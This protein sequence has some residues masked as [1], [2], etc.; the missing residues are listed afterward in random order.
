MTRKALM[1]EDAL[2][3]HVVLLLRVYARYDICW[4]A[5]PN[6]EQRSRTT[7][8]RLKAQGVLPGAADLMFVVDHIFHGLELKT[9]TGKQSEEQ[10]GFET[11]LTNA[12][13]VYHIAYGLDEALEVL[14]DMDV[15]RQGIHFG[16]RS[17]MRAVLAKR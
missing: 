15:F 8:I 10:R 2:Q 6:G 14:R 1:S 3:Q 5:C 13:G 11:S 12:G 16:K 4:W 9:E 7:G 17:A